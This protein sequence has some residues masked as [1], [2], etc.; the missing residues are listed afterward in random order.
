MQ[1]DLDSSALSLQKKRESRKRKKRE[2][3]RGR[4]RE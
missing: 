3:E 1:N 4:K 2:G